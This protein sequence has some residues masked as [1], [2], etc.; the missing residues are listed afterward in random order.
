MRRH[1]PSQNSIG[2][3]DCNG[4]QTRT[5]L[6]GCTERVQAVQCCVQHAGKRVC[7]LQAL[8]PEGQSQNC[9]PNSAGDAR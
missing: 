4:A 2:K 8:S 6:Q 7:I 9:I 5:G 1:C 3:L